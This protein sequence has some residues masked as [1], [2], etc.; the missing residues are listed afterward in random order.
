MFEHTIE[1]NADNLY[2]KPPCKI[3]HAS[4]SVILPWY[5]AAKFRKWLFPERSNQTDTQCTNVQLSTAL[6]SNKLD[7]RSITTD[8]LPRHLNRSKTFFI[9]IVQKY[10]EKYT[11][12]LSRPLRPESLG[13]HKLVKSLS[14][15]ARATAREGNKVSDAA[16]KY[17]RKLSCWDTIRFRTAV[18][19][20][21]V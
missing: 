19:L 6:W 20:H 14:C 2:A 9:N 18:I 4:Y 15:T 12:L 7:Y 11:Y 10:S 13:I 1:Q 8:Q 3:N 21:L 16:D 17:V 5:L